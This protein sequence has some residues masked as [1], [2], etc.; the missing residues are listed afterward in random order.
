MT[1][2]E[3]EFD[4]TERQG[5]LQLREYEDALCP[6][7]GNLRSVCSDP[8]QAWY[9]QRHVCLASKDLAALDRKWRKK[10]ENASPDGAGRLPT[11]GERLWVAPDDLTPDDK[12]L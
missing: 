8:E 4:T 6:D 10:H 7:C 11:D 9:P 2:V 12:F 3:P 5:W 1:E